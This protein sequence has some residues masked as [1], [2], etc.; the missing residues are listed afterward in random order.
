MGSYFRV[1]VVSVASLIPGK[2]KEEHYL[3]HRRVVEFGAEEDKL[4]QRHIHGF[5]GHLGVRV[6]WVCFRMWW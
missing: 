2:A 6:V 3:N 5:T 1:L 4:L